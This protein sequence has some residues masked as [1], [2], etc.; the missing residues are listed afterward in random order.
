M[1]FVGPL[2]PFTDLMVSIVPK[3]AGVFALWDEKGIIYIGAADGVEG[4]RGEL[5]RLLRHEYPL[6]IQDICHFQ[7]EACSDP[8]Q[9]QQEILDKYQRKHGHSPLYNQAV[10]DPD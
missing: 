8:D 9:R 5:E 10:P 4:L 7:V 2:N 1:L 6:A 3:R